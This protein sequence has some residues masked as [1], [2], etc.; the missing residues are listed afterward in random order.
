M[1]NCVVFGDVTLGDGVRVEGCLLGKGV[2]VGGGT[3]VGERCVLGDSVSVDAGKSVPAGTK[4]VRQ[5]DDDG[6]GE[7][8]EGEAANSNT[9]SEYGQFAIPFVEEEDD[10]SDSDVGE[11]VTGGEGIDAGWGRVLD[12]EQGGNSMGK[13]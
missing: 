10:D 8:E 12:P 2:S 13:K 4:L 1:R 9:G 3:V 7:G 6:F 11:R 5:L